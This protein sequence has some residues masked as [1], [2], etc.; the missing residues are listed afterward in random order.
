MELLEIAYVNDDD[1]AMLHTNTQETHIY[2]C[3]IVLSI[4]LLNLQTIY[5]LD[6]E[7]FHCKFSTACALYT[8]LLHIITALNARSLT[9]FCVINMS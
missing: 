4:V 7:I 9:T 3:N 1:D 5:N 6:F 8:H 2:L